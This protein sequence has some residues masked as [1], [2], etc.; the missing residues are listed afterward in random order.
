MNDERPQ[1]DP[2]NWLLAGLIAVVVLAVLAL[3]VLSGDL[4]PDQP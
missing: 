3:V 1:P 2:V 4:I